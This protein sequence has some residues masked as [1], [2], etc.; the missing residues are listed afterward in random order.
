MKNKKNVEKTTQLVITKDQYD[1]LE[2]IKANRPVKKA[3]VKRMIESI[4]RHG[5]LRD[6]NVVW[7]DVKKKYLVAD[8]QH[9]TKALIFL[10]RD[11]DCKITRCDN[12]ADLTQLMIDLNNVSK[13]WQAT[14]YIHGWSESGKKSYQLLQD[15][16]KNTDIQLT[17][18]LMAYTG[19]SRIAATK[20]MR[21]G[22]FNITNKKVGD[23]KINQLKECHTYLPNTRAINQAL[24]GLI[25]SV[26]EYNHKQMLDN[27]KHGLK[28]I[29]L[30]TNEGELYN[31]LVTLY[32][33]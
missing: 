18:V 5:V 27:L 19:L 6:V 15:I 26:G 11:I 21:S 12:D 3:H 17:V 7:S 30:S 32:N 1:S 14:D 28:F 23:K 8:G 10:N 25:N 20:L 4:L 29:Q 16:M 13:S 22:N 33:K 31:Q 2:F 9:L 24:I